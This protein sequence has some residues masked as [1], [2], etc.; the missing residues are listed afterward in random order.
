MSDTTLTSYQ[1]SQLHPTEEVENIYSQLPDQFTH[2]KKF[3]PFDF[4]TSSGEFN[5]SLFNQEFREEQ[6][7]RIQFYRDREIK[8]LKKLQEEMPNPPNLLQMNVGQQLTNMK[9]TFFDI[10][11][12]LVHQPISTSTFTK[13][14]RLFYIGLLLIIIF[15]LYLI[16]NY[17]INKAQN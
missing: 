14:H 1:A 9:N 7:K 8:R 15:I 16:I 17:F 11:S 12:D 10:E 13:N 5:L 4:F 2:Y 6:L 3:S